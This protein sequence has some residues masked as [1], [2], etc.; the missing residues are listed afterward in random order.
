MRRA[1][2]LLA[3]RALLL[4]AALL[5]AMLLAPRPA[6]A[7]L[8]WLLP[9]GGETWT[10]G[11]THTVEWSGGTPSNTVNVQLIQM[12]P[13][14]VAGAIA[15]G[16]PNTGAASWTIP[17]G[18]TPGAY[19]VYVIEPASGDYTYS[20][21]FTVRAGPACPPG[22]QLVATSF[23]FTNPP[24][25]VCGTTASQALAY[26]QGQSNPVCPAGYILDQSSIMTDLTILPFGVCYSGY[27]GAF[28]AEGSSVACCT[29]AATSSRRST[30]GSIK[31]QYH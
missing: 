28:I 14:Q 6:S 15:I 21:T 5:V 20:N 10:A 29:A 8:G 16:V 1:V 23:P 19:Q 25:G 11:T 2:P 7:A 13:F 3:P 30:W 18:I 22:S 17:V 27:S 9:T 4:P 26:A 12:T 31:I 24:S